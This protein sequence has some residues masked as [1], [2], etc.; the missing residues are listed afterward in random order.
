MSSTTRRSVAIVGGGITGASAAA[1]L[2]ANGIDVAVFDQGRRGPGGGASHRSVNPSDSSVM[3]DDGPVPPV[4]WEFDHGCQFFRADSGRMQTLCREWCDRHWAAQWDGRFGSV[5]ASASPDFFGLPTK[6]S[7]VYVGVGGMQRLPRQILAATSAIVHAGV[8]VTNLERAEQ[9]GK[10]EQ[11]PWRLHG[12]GGEAAFHDTSEAQ[13]AGAQARAL[14]NFD[15]V[16]LTD[17]SSSFESW[18]R[19]SAGIPDA[20]AIR[21]RSRV[22]VPL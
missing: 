20:M 6:E 13:A 11:W 17:I 18:H 19:A 9:V 1:S 12:V 14:G 2:A 22:R 15:A 3:P 5:G 4:S 8:R 16:L 10:P 7:P 21:L